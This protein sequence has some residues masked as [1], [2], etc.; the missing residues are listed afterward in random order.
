MSMS[1]VCNLIDGVRLPKD[2]VNLVH[3]DR[4]VRE[5]LLANMITSC[6]G[7]RVPAAARRKN[8]SPG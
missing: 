1:R 4:C 7:C 8:E 3:S 2:V 5:A 6:F